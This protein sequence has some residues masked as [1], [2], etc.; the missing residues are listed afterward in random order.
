M[1]GRLDQARQTRY[2]DGPRRNSGLAGAH[3]A[4]LSVA[5]PTRFCSGLTPPRVVARRSDS[6]PLIAFDCKGLPAARR[7]RIEAAGG[8]RRIDPSLRPFAAWIAA[9]SFRVAD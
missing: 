6:M 4:D 8:G 2:Q 1:A 5:S 3:H 9:T 7:Q